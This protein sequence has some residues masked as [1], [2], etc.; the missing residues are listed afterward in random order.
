MGDRLGPVHAACIRSF[1]RHGHDVVLHS[2][3]RPVDTPDGVAMFDASALMRPDEIIRHRATG[4]LALA[5]D[6]YRFR[7]LKAGMGVYVDCDMFCLQPFPD[8]SY[9][10]GL[11]QDAQV[12]GAVLA[13]PADSKLLQDIMS[14]TEDDFFIPPWS[15]NTVRR[16]W[17]LRKAVGF[18]RHVADQ[19]WGTFGPQLV[20]YMIQKNTL[21]ETAQPIDIFYPLHFQQTSLLAQPGLRIADI[22]TPRTLGLHLYN[23]SLKGL[24]PAAGSPLHEIIQS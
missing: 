15:R 23:Q 14:A 11:E 5:S 12:N 8:E 3:G 18:P 7:L 17:S 20:T 9:L 16:L 24:Q 2:Y 10:Y 6:R 13:M 1:M 19:P 4:S 22:V 21:M